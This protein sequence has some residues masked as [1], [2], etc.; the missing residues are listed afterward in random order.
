GVGCGDYRR[1]DGGLKAKDRE[2]IE[3]FAKMY[4]KATGVRIEPRPCRD[5]DGAWETYE[6][7]GWLRS[8]LETGIWKVIAELDPVNWLKGL[9]D[10]EGW[11]SPVINHKKRLLLA[12]EIRL[13]IGD[14]FLKDFARKKL[15]ELGFSLIEEYYGEKEEVVRG[16]RAR[17]GECWKL[18]FRGW[19]QVKYF[20]KLIGFRVN[21]RRQL[22]QDLLKL[23]RYT[24][25]ER[26][27]LWTLWYQK[28]GGRWR[29]KAY[30]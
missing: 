8:A 2:F 9:Y 29:R 30:L 7:G 12:P 19:N 13:A 10:S 23:E 11:P 14:R 18:R 21:Y 6:S 28:T 4:E 16:M 27:K 24:P 1:T 15:E 22:L 17:F 5:L 3:H 20:A 26:Y 25:K